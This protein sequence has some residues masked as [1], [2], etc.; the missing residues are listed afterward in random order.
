MEK[1]PNPLLGRLTVLASVMIIFPHQV[2]AQSLSACPALFFAFS[3]LNIT[4]V[5][6]IAASIAG[7]PCGPVY[8]INTTNSTISFAV[9]NVSGNYSDGTHQVYL[10]YT[11]GNGAIT[12]PQFNY[13]YAITFQQAM[14]LDRCGGFSAE[15]LAM[16]KV[17]ALDLLEVKLVN[18]FTGA[19]IFNSCNVMYA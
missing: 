18:L 9:M 11:G 7:A 4:T 12:F 5:K 8:D 6:A 1:I 16:F 2:Q 10:K 3:S 14:A 19:Y 15:K 13:S 17:N